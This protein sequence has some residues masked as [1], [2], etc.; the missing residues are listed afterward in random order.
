M[1]GIK[2]SSRQ[3][4][5]HLAAADNDLRTLQQSD[6]YKASKA[7]KLQHAAL[8]ECLLPAFSA[9]SWQLLAAQTLQLQQEQQ[10]Q[11]LSTL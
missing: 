3:E 2:M 10:L 5:A 8:L 6:S 4:G 1:P 9:C 11:M 7:P